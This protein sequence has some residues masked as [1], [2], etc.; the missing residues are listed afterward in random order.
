VTSAL[1]PL[2]DGDLSLGQTV[3]L[4]R[5][6]VDLLL[7]GLDLALVEILSWSDEELAWRA[8]RWHQDIVYLSWRGVPPLDDPS[9][10]NQVDALK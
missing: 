7:G 9:F 2:D 1:A 3:Q 5:Q 4:V 8:L 10:Y 6:R